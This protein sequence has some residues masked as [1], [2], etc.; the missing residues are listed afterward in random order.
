MTTP[1]LSPRDRVA[2]ETAW[3]RAHI[4]A[5]TSTGARTP[6]AR[7]KYVGD[8]WAYIHDVLGIEM[9]WEGQA[10]A[11]E[12]FEK[13]DRVLVPAGNGTG[14]SLLL[15]CYAIYRYDAVASLPGDHQEEQGGRILL[16]GPSHGTVQSVIYGEMMELMARAERRGYPMPGTRSE[17]SVLCRVRPLWEVEAFAPPRRVQQQVTHSASGR[18]HRNQVALI[19]EGQGV[20]E[21]TWRAVEGMC[22]GEGNKILSPFNPTESIGPT[23]SRSRKAGWRVVHLSGLDHPNVR[24]RRPVIPGAISAEEIDRRVEDCTDLGPLRSGVSP[25]PDHGDFLYSLPPSAEQAGKGGARPD[26]VPGHPKGEVH[27]YRPTPVFQGQV[28][29]QWPSASTTGLFDAASIQR[30]QERWKQRGRPPGPPDRIGLDLA[31]EGDDETM[32]AP[33]WG[34]T[35]DAL[36]RDHYQGMEHPNLWLD[37]P[38]PLSGDGPEAQTR[39]LAERWPGAGAVV[40]DE[41]STYGWPG[42]YLRERGL[43]ARGVSFG[44]EAPERLEHEPWIYNIRTCMYYRLA[45]G[46]KLD[47]VDLPPDEQLREELLATEHRWVMKEFYDKEKGR[48]ESKE[49]LALVPKKDI[50]KKIGR[51]PD[52][53]DAVV[54]SCHEAAGKRASK[55]VWLRGGR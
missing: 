5:G 23:Y 17:V 4:V 46:L 33:S 6:A 8:P 28:L 14:K 53:A 38:A 34:L 3:A 37:W 21:P 1:A 51:S 45:R 48:K 29:G 52:R 47:L 54:L 44:A 30:A 42:A 49:A 39:Q 11:L 50:K 9:L 31:G 43:E 25:D 16:V 13:Y 22:S 7:R 35:V 27:I 18:H 40:A 55:L 12:A 36:L 41:S 15:A 2:I 10:E 24:E 26:G 32:A 20:S 19:D